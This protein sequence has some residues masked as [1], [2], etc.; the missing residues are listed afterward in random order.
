MI[1]RIK[2]GAIGDIKMIQEN[3]LTGT[4]WHRG[5]KPEWSQMEYQLRNWLYYNWLSGDH[6][7]EQQI[8]S[9]DKGLWLMDD[10][11]P[12]SCYGS[13]GRLVRTNEKWGNVYDHFATVFEWEGSDVKMF[14]QCRQMAGCFNNVDDYVVGTKG[15]AK[16]LSWEITNE[17]GTQNL[18]QK[19]KPSMYDVE[20][21][22]LFRSIREGKPINNGTYMSYSTLMAIMGREACYTGQKITWDEL[23]ASETRLGPT[24]Y[25]MGDYE[26]A[27]VAKPSSDNWVVKLREKRRKEK[28][29]EEEKRREQEQSD[30]K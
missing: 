15:S 9:L 26:P 24:N 16:V 8:H 25:E 30:K 4:L 18:Q 17:Q 2:D 12:A 6:I 27:P 13:G 23:M 28:K 1:G 3:Y 21:Q 5:D 7:A 29:L 19:G 11:P 20:H 14:S 10:V 22:H